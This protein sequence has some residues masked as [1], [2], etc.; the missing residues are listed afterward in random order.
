VGI[1]SS[2]TAA[3]TLLFDL[4]G[5]LTDGYA[6]VDR[7]AVGLV[8]R[9]L[10]SGLAT[11]FVTGRSR[12]W[13]AANILPVL[14]ATTPSSATS[15]LTVACEN[16]AVVGVGVDPAAWVVVGPAVPAAVV[17]QVHAIGARWAQIVR[18]DSSKECIATFE[19]RHE[20]ARVNGWEAT[21]DGLVR[22]HEKLAPIAVAN[23]LEAR[24]ATYAVDVVPGVLSKR[25]GTQR[26][27]DLL[28]AGRSGG[29]AYVFGDSPGDVEMAEALV[30]AGFTD[31][32]FAWVGRGPA[33]GVPR[34]V[35]LLTPSGLYSEGVV[36][37]LRGLRLDAPSDDPDH[38]EVT[39]GE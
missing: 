3:C 37:V 30:E 36:E 7:T 31:V 18:W 14:A 38:R 23:D 25:L 5:V 2:G 9:A 21:R 22:L 17:D 32:T 6:V 19:V 12:A 13:V 10:S 35:T 1:R 34:G 28:P 24:L 4:D 27:L 33:P 20:V 39:D 8:A 11:A 26:V 16:G 29:P 15:G